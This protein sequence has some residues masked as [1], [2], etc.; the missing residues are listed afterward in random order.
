MRELRRQ[1][2]RLFCHVIVDAF[3]R[4]CSALKFYLF[5]LASIK[6]WSKGTK[7]KVPLLFDAQIYFPTEE[8]TA[9]EM[10]MYR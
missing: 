7:D 10:S 2:L 8:K 4:I 5:S 6:Q 3:F 1:S 9:R